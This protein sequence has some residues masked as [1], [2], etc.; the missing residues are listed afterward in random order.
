M[1]VNRMLKFLVIIA[2][3]IMIGGVSE[4]VLIKIWF[5]ERAVKVLIIGVCC[6]VIVLLYCA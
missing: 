5:I 6:S 2:L 3:F 4:T 1:I